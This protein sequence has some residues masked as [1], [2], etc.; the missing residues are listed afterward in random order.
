M[1]C[2]SA[3]RLLV[4]LL[5][6]SVS[7]KSTHASLQAICEQ[8]ANAISSASQVYYSGELPVCIM[9]P[10]I[11]LYSTYGIR[12][13]SLNYLQDNSH[14]ANSSS[15]ISACSVEPGTVHDIGTI[16]S[17]SPTEINKN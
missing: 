17:P 11:S 15:A 12:T 2:N 10:S 6:V 7:V 13:G 5:F 9:S 1:H 3:K 16:V 8:I 14:W 4:S